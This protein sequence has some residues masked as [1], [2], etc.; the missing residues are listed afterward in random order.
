MI[1]VPESHPDDLSPHVDEH[2]E[3]TGYDYVT[4]SGY[5]EA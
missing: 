2:P 5:L 3:W 4:E 1:L